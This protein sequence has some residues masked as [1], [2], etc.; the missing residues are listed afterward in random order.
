MKPVIEQDIVDRPT[1]WEAGRLYRALM[2]ILVLLAVAVS[3]VW[4]VPFLAWIHVHRELVLGIMIG[5]I[6]ELLIVLASRWSWDCYLW[7]KWFSHQ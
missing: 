4:P 3:P 5:S 1:M 6:A 7:M 2:L